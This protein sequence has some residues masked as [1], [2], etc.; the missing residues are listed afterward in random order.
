MYGIEVR[1]TPGP[2]LAIHA[3]R[4]CP[5]DILH[6]GSS[7]WYGVLMALSILMPCLGDWMGGTVVV[8]I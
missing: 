6:H 4:T 5:K 3:D 8:L 2:L 1:N 7:Y